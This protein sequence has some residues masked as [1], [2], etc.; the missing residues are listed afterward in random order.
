[1]FVISYCQIYTF[2]PDLK[3]GKIVIFRSLQQSTEEIDH[4][5]HFKREHVKFFDR[6]TFHQLK[7]ANTAV[8]SCKKLT[9][10]AERFSVV[11]KFTID[12]LNNWFMNRIKPIFIELDDI[13][14]QMFLKENSI[15]ST[16]TTCCVDDAE[17]KGKVNTGM[18][19]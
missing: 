16:K 1:M 10:L 13:K 5:R 4:L 2:H 3:L 6:T 17:A 14:K 12:T 18:I 15:I 9:F 19:S 11:L 7:D 8:L